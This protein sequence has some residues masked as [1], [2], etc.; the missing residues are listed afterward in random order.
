M[1]ARFYVR[2]LSDTGTVLPDKKAYIF[3][4]GPE[5]ERDLAIGWVKLVS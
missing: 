4:I 1:R 5:N 3:R 2:Q